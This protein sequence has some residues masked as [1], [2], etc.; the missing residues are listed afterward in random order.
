MQY[1]RIVITGMGVVSPNGIGLENFEGALRTG[2]SGIRKVE[3]MKELGFA[4]QVGAKPDIPQALLDEYFSPLQQ[5]RITADGLIYG[6]I[7]AIAA[8]K[9]TGLPFG[10]ADDKEPDWDSGCIFGQGLAGAEV[11]RD[12]TYI[13]DAKKI[14]RLG[15][16]AVPQTMSSGISAHLGGI[17]GLGNQVSSN[18][19][20]CSTG[21]EA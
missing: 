16:S 4:C 19:S 5:K 6:C 12:L 1:K 20:A 3:K 21:T 11:I 8:W 18:S 9:D 17:L 13:V 2:S 14:K 10:S 7:A 15:S